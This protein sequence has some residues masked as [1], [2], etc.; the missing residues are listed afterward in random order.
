MERNETN[1]IALKAGSWYIISNFL[2]KG[3]AIITTP[4][5]TRLLNP[6][7]F[8]ISNTY[9]S[10][11]SILTIVGTLDVVSCIQIARHDIDDNDMN[12]FISSVLSLSTLALAILYIFVK[13]FS[14]IIV[15]FMAIPSLL[16]DIMFLEVLFTNAFTILQTKHRAYFRYREFV[17]LSAIVS[18][19][20]PILSILLITF[21]ESDLYYGKIIGNA[22]P[23]IIISVFIFIYIFKKGRCFFNKEFWK[24][25][26]LIAL[27]LIPHHLSGS[28]LSSFDR[29]M[30]NK[31]DGA[32]KAGLYSLAYNYSS[33]LGIAW[34]SLNSAWVPWFY[35]KMKEDS[36]EDIRR[37]VK[38]YIVVFSTLYMGALI[39]GPEAIK[40]FGPKE[41]WES[42]WVIPP[43]LLAIF[44]Q[45]V[46]SLYVNIEFYLK[47][48]KYIAYATIAAAALNVL[49]NSIFIPKYGYI[50]AAY[51]TLIGY[52]IMLILH[53]NLSKKFDSRDLFNK[54]FLFS[55]IVSIIG[56]TLFIEFFYTSI[57]IRY[58][59]LAIYLF[60]IIYKYKNSI[61]SL[62]SNLRR[63][64]T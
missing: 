20:S 23:R 18:I 2:L 25:A 37:Y 35:T 32:S 53:Y 59:I 49:L 42:M 3:I 21:Q 5:F 26:L 38:P 51:T 33:I 63:K 62:I 44:F 39:V 45:F 11:L 27:P 61:I 1:K 17:I 15:S 9:T 6:D 40:V 30:I 16:I 57:L 7:A 54:P 50:A 12:S 52:F 31:F 34:T 47:K 60:V 41:Y 13:I 64:Q 55:W 24:Y 46:Y 58:L 22:L 28:L 4:I 14:D 29:V 48:T 10:W 56:I 8:G 19:L 43:V 36:I